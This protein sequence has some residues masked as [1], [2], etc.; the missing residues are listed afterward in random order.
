M[1]QDRNKKCVTLLEYWEI[2]FRFDLLSGS[3]FYLIYPDLLESILDL[4]LSTITG[5]SLYQM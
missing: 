1:M 4:T 3:E 5:Y 2:I